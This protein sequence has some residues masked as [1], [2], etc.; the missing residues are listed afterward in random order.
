[1]SD[2]A[3]ENLN[4]SRVLPPMPTQQH[5][6][7]WLNTGDRLVHLKTTAFLFALSPPS[8]PTPDTAQDTACILTSLQ[9]LLGN[10]HVLVAGS[11]CSDNV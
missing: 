11:H 5:T 10:L 2:V 8:V 7:A 6:L 1:M 9:L 4:E 3:K